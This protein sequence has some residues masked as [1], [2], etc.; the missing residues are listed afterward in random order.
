MLARLPLFSPATS[1]E[2]RFWQILA[3]GVL[4]FAW[5][6]PVADWGFSVCLIY[7]LTAL[8]CP[9]CGMPR[10]LTHSLLLRP[11]LAV[12]YHPM[13]VL[14]SL[15]VGGLS[16]SAFLPSVARL[17]ERYRTW[18]AAILLGL[19]VLLALFGLHLAGAMKHA[20]VDRDNTLSSM[21]FSKT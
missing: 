6:V 18:T 10:S 4:A 21:W 17:F 20:L 19:A 13:G 5:L 15:L 1:G 12:Q 9:G 7:N 3:L 2:L 16:L 8:P 14:F 11:D